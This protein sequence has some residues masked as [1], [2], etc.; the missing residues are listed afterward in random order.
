MSDKTK[1]R[2]ESLREQGRFVI[3]NYCNE[4][5]CKD[6]PFNRKEDGCRMTDIDREIDMLK[7][8]EAK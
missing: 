2:I 5:G 4:I 1:A 8:T 7:S 6:C 3:L